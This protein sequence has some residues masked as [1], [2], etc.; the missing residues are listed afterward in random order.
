MAR[1]GLITNR[2][3]GEILLDNVKWC[4]SFL[5]KLRGLMFRR[6][7]L[8]GEGL[9]FVEAGESRANTAIHMFF[10]F[11]S[12]AVIWLDRDFHVVDAKHARP[13]RPAYIPTKPAKYF[14]E[15]SSEILER[16]AIGDQLEFKEN[17]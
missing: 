10:M 14:I 8:Q 11:M 15:T 17:E 12:I 5:C 4:S 7:L 2:E 3:T 6:V 9:L 13:W 1:I 16:V